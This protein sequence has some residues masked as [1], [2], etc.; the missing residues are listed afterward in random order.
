MQIVIGTNN[1]HKANEIISII[2]SN[3]SDRFD[4][5]TLADFLPNKIEINETGST[6]SENAE[7][8]ARGI[9]NILKV[10]VIADD[11]GLEVDILG[12]QPGVFSARYSGIGAS[13]EDNRLK[14]VHQL[15]NFSDNIFPAQ[16]QCVLCYFDG[17]HTI[18]GKG[19][20]MGSIILQERGSNGFG[21]DPMFIPEGYEM[22]FAELPPEIKNAISHRSK[23]LSDFLNNFKSFINQNL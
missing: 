6:F 5:L 3:F 7:L 2:K 19:I 18:K 12:G 23:A 20:C 22:T 16:F 14:L 4:F 1:A 21:Y 13:D 8:K 17:T 9:F 10:P 15:S 11:S